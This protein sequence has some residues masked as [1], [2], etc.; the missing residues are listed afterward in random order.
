MLG[1]KKNAKD[2]LPSLPEQGKQSKRTKRKEKRE[3]YDM[4]LA[5]LIAGDSI[6]E[7]DE[8]L[9]NSKISIGF[10]NISS[11]TIISKYFIINGFPDWMSPQFL[12]TIR[13]RCILPGVRIDFYIYGQPH[14]IRWESAEMRNKMTIWK[15]YADEHAEEVN[16]FEYRA[17]RDASLARDRIMWSTKYLNEAELDHKRTTLRASFIVKISA[18]R[19]DD[20]IFNLGRAI[21]QYKSLCYAS[22]IKTRELKVNMID[23]IQA[24]GVFSL[25]PIR[26][27]T[28]KIS[29]KVLTDD[30]LANFNSYKQG[31]V[32]TAGV[33]L[34]VDVLSKSFVMKKF[35]A[36]PDAP[37]NWLVS[38]ATGGGKSYWVKTLLT[39]L[40]ADGFIVT[41]MDYEGDEYYNLANYIK[42]GNPDD[43]KIISM[44][45]GSTLYFDPM[46]IPMLTGDPDIDDELKEQAIG[47]TLA[48]F[49]VMSCGL[50][51]TLDRAQERVVSTAIRRVYDSAG[52][53]DDKNTWHRSK[54]LR[55][56]MV[57]DELK[58]MV[59]SKEFVDEST[60]NAKHKQLVGIVEN[61][62]IYF[63]EGEA[64][65]GSFKN[66]MSINELFKAKFIVFSFGM[67]GATKSQ[68]DPVILALKQLSVANI[69]IQISN[70]CKYVRKCFNVKVWE[71]YQRWGD[72]KGSSDIISNAMT[73]GRKRGDVNIIITNDLAAMLDENNPINK[74][75]SQNIQS[76]A[77]GKIDDSEV[78]E[79]FCHKFGLRELEP[80]LARIAKASTMD[81]SDSNGGKGGGQG[82]RYKHAFCLVLDNGKKSVVKVIL[83]PSLR[84]SKIFKTG[85]DV[86]ETQ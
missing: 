79:E 76:Y 78:R 42:A 81:A 19:D 10:S 55:V 18:K 14:T 68:M 80:E 65:A 58:E 44:G 67:K 60:D 43:V 62:S 2:D 69:S 70:Y 38:A 63:E 64:K 73:G 74:T 85:V 37:E 41:V 30:I 11:E 86:S 26:E 82:N 71:E 61:C 77:I 40:L 47:Y 9:D 49:R 31:R 51:G 8:E 4:I 7:P 57:Y 28:S 36:D 5:N 25:R 15:N 52:V 20:S 84:D 24:I 39:Y 32:G 48:Y 83:P 75:L 66:P 21:T 13:S 56:S 45:K 16:V 27:V 46:E 17:K 1:K 29:K 72:A 35:K 34:G 53:T 6:I 22:D 3:M 12:D 33:P 59:D 50:D 23:W 54:G